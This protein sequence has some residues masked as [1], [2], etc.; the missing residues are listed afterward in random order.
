MLLPETR[1][2]AVAAIEDRQKSIE[3]L[4][5]MINIRGIKR[6]VAKALQAV[7]AAP[8]DSEVQLPDQQPEPVQQPEPE[9]EVIMEG[10]QQQQRLPGMAYHGNL[11]SKCVEQLDVATGAVLRVYPSGTNAAKLMNIQSTGISLCV[12][13]KREEYYGFAWRLYSGPRIDCKKRSYLTIIIIFEYK[14]MYVYCE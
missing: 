2:F 6:G 8:K 9:P 10:Q 13:G 1:Y 11:S 7:K 12:N 5:N 4:S 14:T 3:E